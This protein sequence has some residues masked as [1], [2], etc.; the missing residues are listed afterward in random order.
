M[1]T[2]T[3]NKVI[4]HSKLTTLKHA[5]RILSKDKLIRIA[6]KNNYPI[7]IDLSYKE[8]CS[9]I[10]RDYNEDKFGKEFYS[11]IKRQAFNP[12]LNVQDGFFLSIDEI[13]KFD[14]K[15]FKSHL[16][17]YD[18]NRETKDGQEEV[19]T[20]K[21]IDE[22]VD[23]LKVLATIDKIKYLYDYGNESS[24]I[25]LLPRR[26]VLEIYPTNNIVYIQTKN[27]GIYSDIKSTTQLLFQQYFQDDSL[28]LTKPKM[29]QSLSTDVGTNGS[30]VSYF[31]I[32]KYTIKFLDILYELENK[33]YNFSEFLVSD[34][35]FDHEDDNHMDLDTMIY[36][37]SF[38]GKNLLEH[39]EVKNRILNGR[40]I[41]SVCLKIIYNEDIGNNKMFM[42]SIDAG[43]INQS[44]YFRM[45]IKDND[46][47]DSNIMEYAYIK[48]KQ[49]FIDS[50]SSKELNN[51][52]KIKKI[53]RSN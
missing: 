1:G 34:I 8:I 38:D 2:I 47:I 48:L 19:L 28:K 4:E 20:F 36:S 12:D 46:K 25:Y 17:S 45:Y 15:A 6:K 26:A 50:F 29:T 31:G 32:N 33:K 49:L 7:G 35:A 24:I 52:D 23:C 42:H 13:Y 30:V 22:S 27:T 14:I 51:E 41:L 37:T 16:E 9:R 18:M 21:V 44:G 11:I 43:I 10:L 5:F 39:D 3:Q 40:V 53:I